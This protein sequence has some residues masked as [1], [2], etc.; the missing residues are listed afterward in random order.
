MALGWR[1]LNDVGGDADGAEI[2]DDDED[3]D[4]DDEDDEDE[5]EEEDDEEDD[6]DEEEF[7][8]GE[9]DEEDELWLTRACRPFTSLNI[10][11]RSRFG[12]FVVF[13]SRLFR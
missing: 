13:N 6:E 3:D 5:E 1:P 10:T 9:L 4:E 7:G 11:L 2:D 8:T 12:W